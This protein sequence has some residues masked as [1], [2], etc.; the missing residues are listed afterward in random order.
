VK[1]SWFES[2]ERVKIQFD[3]RRSQ[4]DWENAKIGESVERL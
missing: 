3:E 4:R 2:D 1:T